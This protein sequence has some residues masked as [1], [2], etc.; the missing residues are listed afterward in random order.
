MKVVCVD[1]IELGK[2]SQGKPRN[3]ILSIT[4]GQIYETNGFYSYD[5]SNNKIPLLSNCYTL[6][7]DNERE[8]VTYPSHYFV[9]LDEWRERQ[10]NKIL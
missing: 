2:D 10:L 6:L 8:S 9:T 4:P 7:K 3:R 5:S 1:N